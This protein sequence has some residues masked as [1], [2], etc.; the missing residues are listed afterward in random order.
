M[1]R[2]KISKLGVFLRE[3][4]GQTRSFFP[5]AGVRIATQLT[6]ERSKDTDIVAGRENVCVVES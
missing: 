1:S 2:G 4:R 3:G 5:G 6:R